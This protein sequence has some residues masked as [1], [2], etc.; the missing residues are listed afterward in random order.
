MQDEERAWLNV[1]SHALYSAQNAAGVLALAADDLALLHRYQ[2]TH[3]ALA[4]LCRLIEPPPVEPDVEAA[5]AEMDRDL[6]DAPRW[7]CGHD[8]LGH[9]CGPDCQPEH[10]DPWSDC[11]T[12]GSPNAQCWAKINAEGQNCCARCSHSE[13]EPARTPS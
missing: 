11:A 8:N 6:D 1:A 13:T 9:T 10:D 2:A 4:E 3:T 5:Q 7:D 12:C